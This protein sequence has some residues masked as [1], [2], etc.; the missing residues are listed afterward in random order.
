MLLYKIKGVFPTVTVVKQP[1]ILSRNTKQVF[2]PDPTAIITMCAFVPLSFRRISLNLMYLM[3]HF[4]SDDVF[5][6]LVFG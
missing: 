1:D 3:H 6:D 5:K 4:N 2:V